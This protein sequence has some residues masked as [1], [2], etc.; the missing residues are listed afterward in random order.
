[1]DRGSHGIHLRSGKSEVPEADTERVY[2]GL[3]A[4]AATETIIRFVDNISLLYLLDR[5]V[6]H[7]VCRSGKIMI[8]KWVEKEGMSKEISNF[9]NHLSGFPE[10][11]QE[12]MDFCERE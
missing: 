3:M 9:V 1:M 6:Y 12:F 5:F 4:Y 10:K 11:S 8:N 7:R 2:I